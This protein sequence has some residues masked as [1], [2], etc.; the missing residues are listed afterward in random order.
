MGRWH[1]LLLASLLLVACRAAP[2]APTEGGSAAPA[3]RPR[4]RRA[5]RRRAGGDGPRRA[6]RRRAGDRARRHDR[7]R[8]RRHLR[9]GA[10]EGLP[11]RARARAG[12]DGLQR[13]P[14]HDSALGADQLDVGGGGPGPGL[15]NAILRGVNV[16][17]VADRSRAAPGTRFNCLAVRKSLLDSGAVRGFADLRGRVFAE[18]VPAVLTDLGR[19]ARA[20]AGG[21]RLAGRDQ[22]HAR[23]PGHADRLRQ[24]RRRLR[25]AG[26]AVHHAGRA[27]RREP[28]LET[29]QRDGAELPDRRD[30]LRPRLRRA[31][32]RRRARLPG[33]PPA[34]APRLPAR[35]LWRRAGARGVRRDDRAAS[36][37]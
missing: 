6:R 18:N 5:V 32:G 10:G 33:R 31:A 8:Q 23:L 25:R 28:V 17:I 1:I 37:A 9:L 2:A 34:R 30:P 29:D 27:A 36:A 15:F 26:R 4:Q 13:R 7:Q 21:A 12:G 20:A 35:L 24:R 22:H 11:A 16:R 14:A 19:R 3:A